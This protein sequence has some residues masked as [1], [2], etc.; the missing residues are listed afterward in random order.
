MKTYFNS[1]ILPLS[2]FILCSCT[3]KPA[4]KEYKLYNGINSQILNIVDSIQLCCEESPFISISF[5]VCDENNC[6]IRISEGTVIPAPPMPPAPYRQI[7]ITETDW[8]LG[9][10]KYND[11]YL[12]F[13]E[14]NNN[15]YF[16]K[17]VEKDS[18]YFDEEP[19][20]KFNV[21]DSRERICVNCKSKEK[22]YFINENDSLVFYD[23]KCLFDVEY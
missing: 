22:K 23:G 7:L 5:S 20:I 12:L 9:Y 6:V 15:G 18:L 11:T 21:Y 1:L 4:N 10:K 19:F 14:S 13:M 16:D 2:I 17:F 8:F 3:N